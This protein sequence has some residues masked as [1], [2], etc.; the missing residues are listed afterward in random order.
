MSNRFPLIKDVSWPLLTTKLDVPQTRAVCVPRKRLF[1]RLDEGLDHKLTLIAAPAGYGKTTLLAEWKRRQALPLAWLSLDEGDNEPSR[2]WTYVIAALQVV[3]EGVGGQARA[4]LSMSSVSVSPSASAPQ[5]APFDSIVATLINELALCGHQVVLVLDDYHLIQNPVIHRS[6]AYLIAHQPQGMQLYIASRAEPPLPIAR[7]RV[8]EQLVELRAADLR[9]TF[10]EVSAFLNDIMALEL[11]LDDVA[12]LQE[13][14]EGWIAALQL[15]ALS[16]KGQKDKDVGRFLRRFTGSHRY[17]VDYL[18]EEILNQQPARR[19]SFLL[20]TSILERLTAPLC[21]AV[22]GWTDS[23]AILE[24]FEH[25]NLLLL[26]LDEERRWY[27]YHQLFATF[28]RNQLKQH[29]P[30]QIAALHQRASAWY[31][32]AGM[33]LEAINHALA[34]EEW[35]RAVRLIEEVSNL[36]WLRGEISTIQGWLEQLPEALIDERPRL[37][38]LRAWLLLRTQ[39]REA[40]SGQLEVVLEALRSFAPHLSVEERQRL[41]GEI[42]A[43]QAQLASL[44]GDLVK[45]IIFSEQAIEQ[46]PEA[47]TLLRAML[48]LNLAHAHLQQ[49]DAAAASQAFNEIDAISQAANDMQGLFIRAGLQMLQGNLRQAAQS[50]QGI[51]QADHEYRVIRQVAYL[52]LGCLSYEWNDLTAA[53]DYLKKG[54]LESGEKG[55]SHIELLLKGNL[56]QVY[57]AQ[58]DMSAAQTLM[59]QTISQTSQQLPLLLQSRAYQA[60]L[61]LQEGD[62]ASAQRWARQSESPLGKPIIPQRGVQ[63]LTLIRLWLAEGKT[64]QALSFLSTLQEAIPAGHQ[65]MELMQILALEA[66]ALAQQN[67]QAKGLVALKK[68]LTLAHPEGYIRT[69]IDMGQPMQRLLYHLRQGISAHSTLP[70]AYLDT[71]LAAFGTSA[72]N[73]DSPILI[74]P[75]TERE[76]DVLEGISK[77]LT[78]AEIANELIVAVSTVRTHLKNLY[79]K[80]GVRNRVE[81]LR[82]AEKMGL[83]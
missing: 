29:Y 68:L 12:A 9:F 34:I 3:W 38:I 72:Q 32:A 4:L 51:L 62:L 1:Q 53:A 39:Q 83:L 44:E 36:I 64:T 49:G 2:F 57:H 14:T 40:L 45:S 17:M 60:R 25:T 11:S 79:A 69:F 48:T 23:Q 22:M 78:N 37:G 19:Q 77:G 73:K 82:R 26:P 76:Q 15:A 6:L 21:D 30:E 42:A 18:G 80:L 65:P 50:Y 27:R 8:R 43:I 47:P 46:W 55:L 63:Y 31:E 70:K 81:A 58:G 7:L 66:L 75:L 10:D 61:A 74:E 52:V 71:L 24:T 33:T 20:Q 5:R 13:R 59:A 35:A 54:M 28:L 67:E 41:E 56:A 16:V